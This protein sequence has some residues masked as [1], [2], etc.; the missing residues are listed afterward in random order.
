MNYKLRLVLLFMVF[1][2]LILT[3]ILF[4]IYT[5]YADFRTE[6][7]Y[8][9]LRKKSLTTA[10]L[11][12]EVKEVDRDLLRIIDQNSINKM[13][14]EKVLI[15]N[16]R[17]KLIYSSIDDEPIHYS[18]RLLA[19]VRQVGEIIYTDADGDETIALHYT[20]SGKDYVILA[21]AYDL[22]GRRKLKNLVQ[23][24]AA[25]LLIAALLISGAGYIY[26]RQIFQPI[27]QLNRSIQSISENKLD[28]YLATSNSEDEL[29][30]L[31]A[32]YNKM[33]ERLNRAFASQ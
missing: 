5:S 31:A 29:N 10:K 4:F 20:E 3:G 12:L 11:L 26:V 33:L 9:R 18:P 21:S 1:F 30:Q 25:S 24:L 22:Y 23:I 8:D 13:L 6:A 32:N 14:D 27:D 7:F 2:I 15:F 16:S 17:N 28:A 19:Q